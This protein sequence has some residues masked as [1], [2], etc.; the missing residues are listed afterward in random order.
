MA[1]RKN[2]KKTI[3]YVTGELFADCAA[4]TLCQECDDATLSAL[5]AEI[6]DLHNDFVSRLSHVEKGQE[7]LFFKKLHEEFT[8]KADALCDRIVKA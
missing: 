4:L 8:A 7:K 5:M 1:N 3:K 2:L 6:I